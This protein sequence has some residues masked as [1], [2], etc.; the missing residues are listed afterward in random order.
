MGIL[1]EPNHC[2]INRFRGR[3]YSGHRRGPGPNGLESL[4]A[5]AE[6]TAM[7]KNIRKLRAQFCDRLCVL[8]PA[9]FLKCS[10]VA[11][12]ALFILA[13]SVVPVAGQVQF[14]ALYSFTGGSDG[15]NPNAGLVQA[16]DGNLYGTTYNGGNDGVGTVFSITTNGAY[17]SLYSFV[18]N[19]YN[20]TTDSANPYYGSLV[21][22]S[23]GNLYGTTENGGTN[24]DGTVFQITTNGTEAVVYSFTGGN[25]G[26]YAF[27]GLVQAG[28]GKLYGTTGNG[29]TNGWGTVFR[30]TTN[31]TLTS[32]Y[33]FTAGAD[34]GHPYAG[35]VRASDGN[36]YG[37]TAFDN[38]LGTVFRITTNGVLTP[39]HYFDGDINGG[40]PQGGL[41]QASDGNLYGTTEVGGVAN[42][43]AGTGGTVFRMTPDGTLTS[44]YAFTG[45]PDGGS[46]L[47]NLVQASDGNLYGTTFYGGNTNLNNGWGYGT[48]FS[49]N[50]NGVFTSLYAFTGAG[51]GGNPVGGLV[52]A[53]DGK[54]YGTTEY[55]GT[56]GYGAIFSLLVSVPLNTRLSG[57]TMVLTWSNPA[58]YLQAA[59]TLVDMFTNI[60]GA[61]SPYTVAITGPQ[62]FFRL[63]STA[64][65]LVIGGGPGGG[66][67]HSSVV[68]QH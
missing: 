49:I 62:Q 34:G 46:P 33:A 6:R 37:T 20:G 21:Q 15:R 64:P 18:G 47:A 10:P 63:T 54:L 14:Q 29:G 3:H 5:N 59:P 28:D 57:Q 9:Q 58:F 13:G 11:V 31:G 19:V 61:T 16:S 42:W 45:G 67:G 2:H 51:D 68:L 40:Y 23:D 24:G 1:I 26:R 12:A 55:G 65:P 35:L 39:L 8:L 43:Y 56:S 36:L 17:N 48:L 7:K 4:A 27:G 38:T 44:L 50:T 41:V 60:P 22:A 30:I 25:D 32:L 66:G 52:Q 53:S